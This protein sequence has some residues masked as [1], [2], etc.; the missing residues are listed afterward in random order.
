MPRKFW[1][2]EA[3]VSK[4][5]HDVTID[6]FTGATGPALI[7]FPIHSIYLL[8]S[9][10]TTE[11]AIGNGKLEVVHFSSETLFFIP[12][13][14]PLS[15]RPVEPFDITT[16][17]IPERWFKCSLNSPGNYNQIEF[18]HFQTNTDK[19]LLHAVMLL[20]DL[21][22]DTPNHV[23]TEFA[24]SLVK[25][26]VDRVLHLCCGFQRGKAPA[27]E[28]VFSAASMELINT[29]LDT[30]LDSTIR[31]QDLANLVGLSVFHFAREFKALTDQT[32]MRY[33]L[34]RRIE[35]AKRR[36]LEKPRMPLAVI[37]F[38]CGFSSQSHFTTNFRQVTGMTP[39]AWRSAIGGTLAEALCWLL[40]CH[41]ILLLA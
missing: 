32:P 10:A 20:K 37:A 29:F 38:E 4:L 34:E 36:M 24:K 5:V 25:S 9:K 6:V 39:A 3:H 30:N 15:C 14:M 11:H 12:K 27:R 22:L 17:T 18:E 16:V 31:L 41:E 21:A 35:F 1:A 19:V 40:E 8:E 33:L 23:S 7:T 13:G 26:V 2:S 28:V